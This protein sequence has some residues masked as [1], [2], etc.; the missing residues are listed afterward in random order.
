M[1]S[2]PP[3]ITAHFTPIIAPSPSKCLA[4]CMANSLSECHHDEQ[5]AEITW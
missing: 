2:I 5:G 4:I 1:E 3:T